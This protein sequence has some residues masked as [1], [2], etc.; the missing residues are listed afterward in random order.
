MTNEIEMNLGTQPLDAIM[1]EKNIKNNDLVAVAP[2]GFITHKQIQKGRK[3]RRLTMHMQQKVLDALNAYSAPEK[4]EWEQLF[5][6]R[7]KKDL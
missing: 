4:Y 3:G 1:T 7:G 5:T 2:P 6:Y